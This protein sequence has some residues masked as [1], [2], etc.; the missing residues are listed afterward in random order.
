MV[1]YVIGVD[2]LKTNGDEGGQK[3]KLII[4]EN[5]VNQIDQF[6]KTGVLGVQILNKIFRNF[7]CKNLSEKLRYHRF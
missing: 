5:V 6:E 2:N 1:W 4:T 3:L 7:S